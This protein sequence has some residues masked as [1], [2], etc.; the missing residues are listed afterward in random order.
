M[1]T[2]ETLTLGGGG[3]RGKAA[4]HGSVLLLRGNQKAFLR[5]GNQ[6]VS[7]GVSARARLPV[8]AV[9]LHVG[10]VRPAPAVLLWAEGTGGELQWAVEERQWEVDGEAV[11]GGGEAVKC[12]GKEESD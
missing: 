11:G 6:G 8:A 2:R 9:V 5:G 4:E 12:I 3:G 1:C 10:G 7:K